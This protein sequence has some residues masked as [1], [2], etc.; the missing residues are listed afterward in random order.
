MQSRRSKAELD[1]IRRMQRIVDEAMAEGYLGLSIDMLPWHR[2]DELCSP[3]FLSADAHPSDIEAWHTSARQR[4]L[5]ATPNALTK[6]TVAILGNAQHGH[7]PQTGRHDDRRRDGHQDESQNLQDRHDRWHRAHALFSRQHPLAALAEP[8]LNYCDGVRTRR[9]SRSFP[10]ASRPAPRAT[11]GSK[12]S[13]TP[14]FAARFAA[15]SRPPR[16]RFTATWPTCGWSPAAGQAGK[17][18]AEQLSRRA[19]PLELFLTLL[20]RTRFGDSLENSRHKRPQGLRRQFLLSHDTTLPGSNDS[21]AHVRN[22][23]FQDGALQMLQ[24]VLLNPQLMPLE[25]AI[26]KLTGQSAAWLGLDCGLCGPGVGRCRRDFPDEL[27][28]SS[29]R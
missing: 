26:H 18:F 17:S 19:E 15:T 8:F 4:V 10:P 16:T 9:C 21:G 11:T 3:G 7:R 6:S 13:P 22:M 20:G 23:A 14:R 1:E 27:R 28:V 2:L 5:Q 25:K 29:A 24:Q 12:C